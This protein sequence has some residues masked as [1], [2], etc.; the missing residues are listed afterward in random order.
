MGPT[1][2]LCAV[3]PVRSNTRVILPEQLVAAQFQ[4]AVLLA[5]PRPGNRNLLAVN[6]HRSRRGPPTLALRRSAQPGGFVEHDQ[7]QQFTFGLEQHLRH[8]LAESLGD[9]RQGQDHLNA[10]RIR[11]EVRT[12]LLDGFPFVDLIRSLHLTALLAYV[13]AQTL[14]QALG[15]RAVALK[16]Q[17]STIFRTSS[18]AVHTCRKDEELAIGRLRFHQILS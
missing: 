18:M 15:W 12:E 13:I 9:L 11:N 5:H 16:S 2:N 10:A 17:K 3:Q 4:F 8:A 7:H 6:N 1:Y 14:S